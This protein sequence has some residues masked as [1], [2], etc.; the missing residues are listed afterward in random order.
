MEYNSHFSDVDEDDQGDVDW[1]NVSNAY[2][3]TDETFASVTLN[4][5][6]SNGLIFSGLDSFD[7]EE[8]TILKVELKFKAKSSINLLQY[9]EYEYVYIVLLVDDEYVYDSDRDFV[10]T[11]TIEEYVFDLTYPMVEAITGKNANSISLG[12]FAISATGRSATIYIDDVYVT[13]HYTDKEARQLGIVCYDDQSEEVFNSTS[14]RT[15]I[16]LHQEVVG[17]GSYSKHIFIDN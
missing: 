4:Y 15:M 5:Q 3:D 16:L 8:N 13:I 7:F 1:S 14:I 6:Y 17:T 10:T 12:L 9:N 11:T 2:D